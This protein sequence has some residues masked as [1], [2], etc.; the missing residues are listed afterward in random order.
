MFIGL[1]RWRP[2]L[3]EIPTNMLDDSDI[4]L[5]HATNHVENISGFA[6]IFIY[7]FELQVKPAVERQNL[8][9]RIFTKIELSSLPNLLGQ[10]STHWVKIFS[11]IQ[12]FH[13][14]II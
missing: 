13:I 3:N 7:N 8:L 5:L 10:S 9:S 4:S 12:I 2:V 1:R 14:A 6:L 11:N